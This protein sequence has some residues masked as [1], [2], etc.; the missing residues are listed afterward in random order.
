[1]MLKDFV[2]NSKVFDFVSIAIPLHILLNISLIGSNKQ[3]TLSSWIK[4]SVIFCDIQ[5]V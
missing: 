3:E 1:M 5:V 2:S 4:H